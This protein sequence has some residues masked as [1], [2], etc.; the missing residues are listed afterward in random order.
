MA[1]R[2]VS[3]LRREALRD[4]EGGSGKG[5]WLRWRANKRKGKRQSNR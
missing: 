1:R 3:K 4:V 2:K 5:R